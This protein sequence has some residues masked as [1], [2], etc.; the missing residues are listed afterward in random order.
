MFRFKIAITPFKIILGSLAIVHIFLLFYWML[1]KPQWQFLLDGDHHHLGDNIYN[2]AIFQE[3]EGDAIQEI[4]P[5]GLVFQSAFDL[6]HLLPNDDI[7]LNDVSIK[8]EMEVNH[9]KPI[10]SSPVTIR[11]NGEFLAYINDF[12]ER[13][14]FEKIHISIPVPSKINIS[15][16][17]NVISISSGWDQYQN[18]FEDFE[19]SNLSLLISSNLLSVNKQKALQLL[20]GELLIL[21]IISGGYLQYKTKDWEKTLKDVIVPTIIAILVWGIQYLI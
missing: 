8:V 4:V 13:E 15:S 19:F 9:V 21:L 17:R 16:D 11:I 10:R 14:S 12:V 1:E 7:A 20:T 6:S 2:P 3:I 18:D 5:E